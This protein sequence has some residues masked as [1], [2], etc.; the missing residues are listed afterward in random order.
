MF[1]PPALGSSVHNH[2]GHGHSSLADGA[3]VSAIQSSVSIIIFFLI[4][5]RE[6]AALCCIRV[7]LK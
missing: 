5:S 2:T 1:A 7:P 4:P 6:T 3:F